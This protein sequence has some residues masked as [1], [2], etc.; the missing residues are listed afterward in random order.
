MLEHI[1]LLYFEVIYFG[2]FGVE[3]I[4]NENKKI[5]GNKNI[6]GN[7]FDS[8]LKQFNNVWTVLRWIL[9]T[10]ACK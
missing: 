7:F 10:Y 1:G 2:S 9:W 8:A 3:H 5:I 4:P 6:K